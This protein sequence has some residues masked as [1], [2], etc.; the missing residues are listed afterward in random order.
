[1][2]DFGR[3][4]AD[5]RGDLVACPG[6]WLGA[7]S[8]L[9]WRWL[10]A[11][12]AEG[13]RPIPNFFQKNSDLSHGLTRLRPSK[14]SAVFNRF[15]HSAGPCFGGPG[16]EARSSWLGNSHATSPATPSQPLVQPQPQPLRA[17]RSGPRGRSSSQS[18]S[19]GR[20]CGCAFAVFLEFSW[21]PL[22]FL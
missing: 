12:L 2:A 1:M 3:K 7:G 11:D 16:V 5:S 9:P 18:C 14:G 21:L 19:S 20:V 15:A 22:A 17:R 4:I 10:G 13:A 6:A 8:A